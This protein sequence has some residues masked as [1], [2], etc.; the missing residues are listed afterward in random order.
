[1]GF[2]QEVKS[3]FR[4]RYVVVQR[5]AETYL[6]VANTIFNIVGGAVEIIQLGAITTA[7]AV[8]AT[9]VRV[10]VNGIN[11]DAAAV[12][13]SG[14]V[15]QVFYC[16]LN[17]A[18]TLIQAA[19]VPITVATRTTMISGIQPAAVGTIVAT[20]TVGTSFTGRF[21]VVY[22]RLSPGSSIVVA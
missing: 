17:V 13:I 8:G 16:S 18:G 12:D 22:R 20:F 11:T 5:P 21:W 10:T 3:T 7:A 9:E 2:P 6:A 1:M 4:D 14:A 15:G 19:A